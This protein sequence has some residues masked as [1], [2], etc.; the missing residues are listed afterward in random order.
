MTKGT[1][2]YTDRYIDKV[3]Y[4]LIRGRETGSLGMCPRRPFQARS[5]RVLEFRPE[6]SQGLVRV[7]ISTANIYH[8]KY[9]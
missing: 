9:S 3:K 6:K 8:H 5:L 2:N 4:L 1:V 7:R